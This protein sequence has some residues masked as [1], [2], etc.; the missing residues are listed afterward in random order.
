MIK[1]DGLKE[2]LVELAINKVKFTKET[3]DVS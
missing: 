2:E 1:G 3:Q